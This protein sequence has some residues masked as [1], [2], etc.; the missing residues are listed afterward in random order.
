MILFFLITLIYNYISFYRTIP[1]IDISEMTSDIRALVAN[2]NNDVKI[3]RT[4]SLD[5]VS[6]EKNFKLY[7]GDYVRTASRSTVTLLHGKGNEIEIGEDSLLEISSKLV[8]REGVFKLQ[9]KNEPGSEISISTPE[10]DFIFSNKREVALWVLGLK[11]R[12]IPVLKKKKEEEEKIVRISVKVS[13]K[14][15]TKIEILEG[16]AQ[17]KTKFGAAVTLKEGEEV[18][19]IDL[20]AAETAFMQA[21][22]SEKNSD[23]REIESSKRITTLHR[24]ITRSPRLQIDEIIWGE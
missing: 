22:S 18:K 20:K 8:L 11:I 5:W 7:G 16:I 19:A 3:K 21:Q 9:M 24:K 14:E 17:V 10:G 1:S 13:E 23:E 12:Q 2:L 4:N 6:A 15:P